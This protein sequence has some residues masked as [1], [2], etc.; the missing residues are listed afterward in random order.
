MLML[1]FV[2]T[3]FDNDFNPHCLKN[4]NLTEYAQQ[5]EKPKI[6]FVK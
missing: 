5:Y 4:Q 3:K 6:V 2:L 1:A